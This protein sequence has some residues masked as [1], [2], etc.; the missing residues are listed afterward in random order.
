MQNDY[1][2]N[3]WT[4]SVSSCT[5]SW[6]ESDAV[7][8]SRGS[9]DGIGDGLQPDTEQPEAADIE[10]HVGPARSVLDCSSNLT[11]KRKVG[12]PK[13]L[14]KTHAS[15]SAQV[16]TLSTTRP[17]SLLSQLVH[18]E[19]PSERA[20]SS[21]A[22]VLGNML[23]QCEPGKFWTMTLHRLFGPEFVLSQPLQE[24]VRLAKMDD[25]RLD[26]K[27]LAVGNHFLGQ[28]FHIFSAVA[29][30]TSLQV[31][32]KSLASIVIK[33]ACAIFHLSRLHK[34]LFEGSLV[35]S[36]T[37][38]Q[39]VMYADFASYDET[40]MLTRVKSGK[41]LS[42]AMQQQVQQ[43]LPAHLCYLNAAQAGLACP[44]FATTA[45]LMQVKSSGGMLVHLHG[46]WHFFLI[47]ALQPL[48][49]LS[50]TSG[51][52]IRHCMQTLSAVTQHSAPYGLHL[53]AV[54][55]DGAGSNIV[56]ER[57]LQKEHW[58]SIVLFCATHKV[59]RIHKRVFDECV[60][61]AIAGLIHT[62]LAIRQTGLRLLRHC[63]K[64]IVGEHL[65][66]L[67]G[68]ASLHAN[69]VRGNYLE[70]FLNK[71]KSPALHYLLLSETLNGDWHNL[72]RIE[73]Y[74][75]HGLEL[76]D[77]GAMVELVS[78][79]IVTCL[80]A[81]LPLIWPRHRWTGSEEA[82]TDI[83]ALMGIHGILQKIFPKFM[84]MASRNPGVVQN[85]GLVEVD[86]AAG[87]MGFSMGKPPGA[88]GGPH[89]DIDAAAGSASGL[90]TSD[91]ICSAA[92]P[93]CSH[94]EDNARMRNNAWNWI[95]QEPF[96]F[97]LLVKIV[98]GPLS[99]LLHGILDNNSRHWEERQQAEAAKSKMAREPQPTP[100]RT[101]RL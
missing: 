66:I 53:R 25:A 13:K 97:L 64:H 77:R 57:G 100:R 58:Q 87:M 38:D 62:S 7:V 19:L 99:E 35:N 73:H 3:A 92:A 8:N 84:Q 54:T 40:P 31:S 26:E 48:C 67:R 37:A 69:L 28:E 44:D 2:G 23:G 52:V 83:M 79:S 33:L 32:R 15:T 27:T 86:D 36:L 51:P 18:A 74:V 98:V 70:L 50:K 34:K 14:H 59:A 45:K 24:C 9:G 16:A 43:L 41:L 10:F 17:I 90:P 65:V 55:V 49:A 89:L 82:V 11:G 1:D 30:E 76:P 47:D 63:V 4:A 39:L 21:S 81:H 71:C 91:P 6:A 96:E 101:W 72:S 42:G 61:A 93:S 60:P 12:R 46:Q 88:D 68:S 75:P 80:L 78:N 56:A 95:K 94:A 20:A 5:V 85:P 22:N 29:A